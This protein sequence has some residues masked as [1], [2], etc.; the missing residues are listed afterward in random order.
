MA[1]ARPTP[2]P[3]LT[4]DAINRAIRTVFIAL[5]ADIF[6][7]VWP[8]IDD[9]LSGTDPVDW[10]KLWEVAARLAIQ[11]LGA[12]IL[13]RVLDPSGIPTPLPPDPLPKPN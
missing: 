12:F 3:R 11:A 5:F 9:A 4:A 1:T 13:R 6:L 2:G 7:K 10:K 8:L